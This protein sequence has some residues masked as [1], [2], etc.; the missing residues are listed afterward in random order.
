[1]LNAWLYKDNFR[2]KVN[3]K[4]R[5]K[6]QIVPRGL[7]PKYLFYQVDLKMKLIW[8]NENENNRLSQNKTQ[9]NRWCMRTNSDE[10]KTED[11]RGWAVSIVVWGRKT[12]RWNSSDIP[13]VWER[14]TPWWN[15]SHASQPVGVLWKMFWELPTVLSGCMDDLPS[16]KEN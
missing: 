15:S 8:R 1:M 10:P 3:G 14:A 5:E 9:W 12:P 7:T 2:L 4:H 6:Q 13:I 11:D 16:F